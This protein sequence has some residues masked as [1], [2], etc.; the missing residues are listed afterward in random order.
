[1]IYISY[2]K[3][4]PEP[5]WTSWL[6]KS[7]AL[8][9]QLKTTKKK[10]IRDKIITNNQKHWSELKSWLRTF[11]DD[12]CWFTEARDLCSDYHVEHFR[13]KKISKDLDN[14]THDGYWWLSFDWENFRLC[15][16]IPNTHKSTYFP[17]HKDCS[18]ALNQLEDIRDE[19]PLLLDPTNPND[20]KL[21]SFIPTGDAV[22]APIAKGWSF[23]RAENSIRLYGL[24]DYPPLINAR[25]VVWETCKQ[26]LKEYIDELQISENMEI[27]GRNN[28]A[29]RQKMIDIGERIFKLV[30]KKSEFSSV[31]RACILFTNDPRVLGFLQIM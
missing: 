26:C 18:R 22:P 17:L 4:P 8:L 29:S 11:S 7:K 31:A 9:R 30:D 13:P 2:K 5:E 14:V 10:E 3:P 1:M 25:Q 27:I 6:K 28:I 19:N 16:S 20:P 23:E 21:I 15:G 24:N 12:K